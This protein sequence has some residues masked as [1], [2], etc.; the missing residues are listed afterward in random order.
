MHATKIFAKLSLISS[1]LLVF[2]LLRGHQM[3][4]CREALRCV[5]SWRERI[6]ANNLFFFYLLLFSWLPDCCVSMCWN[7]SC[8]PIPQKCEGH[9]EVLERGWRMVSCVKYELK[10]EK[11]EGKLIKKKSD[12]MVLLQNNS[13]T[14]IT[15]PHIT[16]HTSLIHRRMEVGEK[17]EWKKLQLNGIKAILI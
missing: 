4:M 1:H 17:Y 2:S 16:I 14:E 15:I 9:S 11:L 10:L 8:Y 12:K 13:K 3:H 5:Q 6:I 7:W